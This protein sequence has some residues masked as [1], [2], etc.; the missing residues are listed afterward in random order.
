M[1]YDLPF[2]P[3]IQTIRVFVDDNVASCEINVLG[4][5]PSFVLSCFCF[6]S[7]FF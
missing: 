5:G 2:L 7:P 1:L 4:Y 6:L 3:V